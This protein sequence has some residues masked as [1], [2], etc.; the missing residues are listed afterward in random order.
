MVELEQMREKYQL[1]ER[2]ELLGAVKPGDV[3]DVS[4]TNLGSSSIGT[5]P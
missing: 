5:V 4:W 2:V 3:R 1:Q